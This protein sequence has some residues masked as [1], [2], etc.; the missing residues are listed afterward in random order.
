MRIV[1]IFVLRKA[2]QETVEK[3]GGIDILVR[4]KKTS[5]HYNYTI[6]IM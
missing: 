2:I 5:L 4:T 6:L 1:N 3:F